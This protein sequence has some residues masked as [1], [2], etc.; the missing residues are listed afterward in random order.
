MLLL[1]SLID[2]CRVNIHAERDMKDMVCLRLGNSKCRSAGKNITFYE[3]T[4]RKKIRE[5]DQYVEE[6][7]IDTSS[8]IMI[9]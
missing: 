7:K 2:W 9:L 4:Q 5:Y 1:D 6:N 3:G 8:E